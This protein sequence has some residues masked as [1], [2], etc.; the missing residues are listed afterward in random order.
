MK[1]KST[2]TY[3]PSGKRLLMLMVKTF[4]FCFC[5]SVF[6]LVPSD[7]L[8]QNIKI[9]IDKDKTLTVDEVFYLIMDQTDYK[10]IYQKSIFEDF[11]NVELKKGTISAGRL[12]QLSIANKDLSVVLTLDNTIL[13]KNK[14][15]LQQI[16]ITGKVIDKNGLGIPGVTVL[17]KGTNK[18]V[19]TDIEGNYA[20]TVSSSYNILVFSSLGFKIQEVLV[21]DQKSINVTLEENFSELEAVEL[22][23]T[24]YQTISKE[25]STGSFSKPNMGV[26]QNR[27]NSMDITQRLEGLV[28]GLSL[29][30]SPGQ[31]LDPILIRG[32][33]SVSLSSTPLFVVDGIPIEDV[34]TNQFGLPRSGIININP[35]DIEDIT[36]LRDATAA[37][38]WGARAAN[39]VIV[40]NTKKG[41]TSGEVQI[42]YDTFLTMQGTPDMSYFDV[43]NSKDFIQIAEDIFDPVRNTY[44]SVTSFGTT[45][46]GI[47][48]HERILYDQDR[49][50]INNATARRKLDSLASID[51]RSQIEKLWYRPSILNTHTLSVSAG[52]KAYSF[53][54]SGNYTNTQSNRPGEKNNR[55]KLNLRQNF[56]LGKRVKVDLITDITYQDTYSPNNIGIDSRY[57]PYQLFRDANG[58]NIEMSHMTELNDDVRADFE[59]QSG[60]DLGYTPLNEV[61]YE[62]SKNKTKNFR[63]ILGLDVDIFDGLSFVGRYGY[64]TN[65]VDTEN[66]E[67]HSTIRARLEALE[68]AVVSSPGATPQFVVP[69]TGGIKE[70]N[71]VNG[72]TWTIRNQLS[73]SKNWNDRM[74]QVNV[75]AGQEAREQFSYSRRSRVRGFD[76]RLQT[77]ADIDYSS[78]ANTPLGS[79]VLGN[80][81]KPNLFAN[82]PGYGNLSNL[83]TLVSERE[84]GSSET[85]TRFT[86]Y[87]ANAAYTFNQKYSISGSFRNDQSNLFGLDKSAQNKPAWS[88]GA[89]WDVGKENF[90]QNDWLNNLSLRATYGISGNSPNPGS[91]A[92]FDILAATTSNFFPGRTGLLITTPGNRK[93][94]WESTATTNFGIDF[95]LFGRIYGAIDYYNRKTTDLLGAIPTNGFTG[96]NT[97]TGNL[98]DLENN[99]IELSLNTKNIESKDFSWSSS[100]NG[101]Y[102]KNTITDL[103]LLFPP[104][105]GNDLVN[106]MYVTGYSAYAV[107]AYDYAG[108]DANGDPQ[109][110]LADG[111]VSTDPNITE[112]ED[113]KYMG[114]SQPKWTGGLG[115]TFTYKNLSLNVNTIFNLGHVLRRDVNQFYSGTR[116]GTGNSFI[117]GNI[118]SDFLNRWQQSGDEA[119]TDI[120]RHVDVETSGARNNNYYIYGSN[121]VISG[122]FIKIRDINLIYN[123]PSDIFK[124]SGIDQITLRGQVSNILLWTKNDYG[125]DPEYHQGVGSNAG[126]RSVPQGKSV[127][128]GLNVK[129]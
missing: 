82:Y 63:N 41:N 26:I 38:I 28:P 129:F 76:D 60:L 95:W 33:S 88:V 54:G 56:E 25:R 110:R 100:L 126:L 112:I 17:I 84:V 30:N 87:Y 65:S 16:D 123:L 73:Y 50:V 79:S 61:D 8:S 13:I 125:I 12:L 77:Y 14:N 67:D 127:T 120:P 9:K 35:Q 97:V 83:G 85:T 102:N 24:G 124:N 2:N 31:A 92:S 47:P 58:N 46:N 96:Y 39:G 32:L 21:E 3:F 80:V 64:S 7:V 89:K 51:N 98:G 118:H 113:I 105:S 109:V 15:N 93:L 34:G 48:P 116:I 36:V 4:I 114:T 55:Y 91:A 10:F 81:I 111:T 53:Y 119:F 29:D 59:N 99:G 18:G 52:K 45:G 49:G 78:Y 69:I 117:S 86:S 62:Y 121:N 37:S 22:V 11:P 90:I 23:S 27:T 70:T 19:A 104:T 1:I 101:A 57:I 42:Q 107:F 40:I 44:N 75:I 68:Y 72:E 5:M 66:F 43:L 108:L 128:L 122:S 71:S 74:H 94:S 103:K 20:I 115:N 6:S 106:N